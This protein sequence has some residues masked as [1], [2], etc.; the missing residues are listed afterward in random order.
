[1]STEYPLRMEH[2]YPSYVTVDDVQVVDVLETAS[3]FHQLM[4]RWTRY[5]HR[6]STI[7]RKMASHQLQPGGIGL[8]CKVFYDVFLAH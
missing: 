6:H 2:T 1:M 8:T 7:K 3:N 5:E 4:P